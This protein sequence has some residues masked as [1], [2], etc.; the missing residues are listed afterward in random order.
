MTAAWETSFPFPL[1]MFQFATDRTSRQ[2]STSYACS[3]FMK[4][5]TFL[6]D[7]DGNVNEYSRGRV[8]PSSSISAATSSAAVTRIVTRP[9]ESVTRATYPFLSGRNDRVSSAPET[10]S[11]VSTCAAPSTRT[12]TSAQETYA[13]FFPK[14]IR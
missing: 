2:N 3:P 13:R 9:P 1:L 6:A 7:P 12:S 14:R 4:T 8:L 10:V 5:G 11:P